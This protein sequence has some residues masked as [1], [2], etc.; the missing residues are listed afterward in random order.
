[1]CGTTMYLMTAAVQPIYILAEHCA[2]VGAS[3]GGRC[4]LLAIQVGAESAT[5]LWEDRECLA[6]QGQSVTMNC[7]LLSKQCYICT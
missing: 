3:R 2:Y 4:G 7:R 1:M 5:H 6:C